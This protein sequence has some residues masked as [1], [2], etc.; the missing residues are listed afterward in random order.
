MIQDIDSLKWL[1]SILMIPIGWLWHRT[2][3]MQSIADETR[4]TLAERHYKKLEVDHLVEKS[5]KPI[6][7][8]LDSIS[9]DVKYL[10]RQRRDEVLK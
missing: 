8:K 7:D 4:I 5:I 6:H 1:W 3:R 2:N 9:D 10:V